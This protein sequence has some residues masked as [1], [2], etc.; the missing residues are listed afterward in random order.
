MQHVN[1]TPVCL[2]YYFLHDLCIE[3]SNR[4]CVKMSKCKSDGEFD[5]LEK[6]VKK[7]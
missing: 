1:K 3:H 5:I 4:K 7:K 2:Q 6:L